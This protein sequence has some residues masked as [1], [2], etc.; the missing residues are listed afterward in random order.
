MNSAKKIQRLQNSI[1][2]ADTAAIKEK[3][4]LKRLKAPASSVLWCPPRVF[5]NNA[6]SDSCTLIEINGTDCT[7]FLHAVTHTM[8]KLNLKIVSAHVYT[9]GSRIVDVFYVTDENGGKITGGDKVQQIKTALLD[10]INGS[11]AFSD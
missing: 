3:L 9:Y 2:R 5:I 6:A 10:T 8:T 7:G 11:A 1:M 4:R